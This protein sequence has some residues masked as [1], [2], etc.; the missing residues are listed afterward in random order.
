MITA[1]QT[2]EENQTRWFWMLINF[3]KFKSLILWLRFY[4]ETSCTAFESIWP[5]LLDQMLENS[6]RETIKQLRNK[7]EENRN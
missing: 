3:M 4:P 6:T 1:A 2:K 7:I 5:G